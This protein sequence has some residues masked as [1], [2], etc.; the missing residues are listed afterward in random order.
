MSQ[1][2]PFP[3]WFCGFLCLFLSA[4]G[5]DDGVLLEYQFKKGAV[6]TYRGTARM[7]A[8][9]VEGGQ[10]M[11]IQMASKIEKTA[12]FLSVDGEGVAEVAVLQ[13]SSPAESG[14]EGPI[15]ADLLKQTG[16]DMVRMEPNGKATGKMPALRNA[17]LPGAQEA[18]LDLPGLPGRRVKAGETWK[19]DSPRLTLFNLPVAAGRADCRM[20]GMEEAGGEPCALLKLDLK[21]LKVSVD[22]G[23][24]VPID[25]LSVTYLEGSEVRYWVRP[26]AGVLRKMQA[27]LVTRFDMPG[28]EESMQ[29]TTDLEIELA[30]SKALSEKELGAA[31]G[32]AAALAEARKA[33]G[34]NKT[35]EAKAGLEK[36][37]KDNPGSEWA[38]AAEGLLDWS[39]K[40]AGMMEGLGETEELPVSEVKSFD[41]SKVTVEMAS[42]RATAILK[43]IGERT[44][45]TIALGKKVN[46][47]EVAEFKAEGERFW[48][49]LD[50]LCG[51]T[52]N[53]YAD[54]AREGGG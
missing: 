24:G 8:A 22:F 53:V 29:M 9:V 51:M 47:V 28:R 5:P 19:A 3:A 1:F 30:D 4:A 6:H 17:F 41:P 27:K 54:E 14:T 45:N 13:R 25:D 23:E 26:E 42:A 2:R 34:E 46:D 33:L 16:F 48:E 44:G 38:A 31:A 40:M 52:G 10:A 36:L 12:W 50:R 39:E 35:E 21:D 43:E 18:R 15:P 20:E 7:K 37:K 11:N 49:A 32:N